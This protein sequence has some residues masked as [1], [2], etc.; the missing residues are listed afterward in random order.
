MHEVHS[1]QN[2]RSILAFPPTMVM[3]RDGHTGTHFPHPLH[4][5]SS[6]LIYR[7]PSDGLIILWQHGTGVFVQS[8][9]PAANGQDELP[10][11]PARIFMEDGSF[12]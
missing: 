12:Q 8:R 5:T 3:L 6:I 2:L 1:M 11:N 7:I 4:F 9:R 10:G